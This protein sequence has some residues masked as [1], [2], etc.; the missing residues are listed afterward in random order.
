MALINRKH[1][2]KNKYQL[3]NAQVANGFM[4]LCIDKLNNE[5]GCQ[6]DKS[7][8]KKIVLAKIREIC[9]SLQNKKESNVFQ[10]FF[11]MQKK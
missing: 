11:N 3:S 10:Y 2:L 1:D 7:T 6:F 8:S 5:Y 4:N 9:P